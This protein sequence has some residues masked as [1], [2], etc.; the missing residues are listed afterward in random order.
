MIPHN[1]DTEA[2]LA[3][4][5]LVA[6]YTD[7]VNRGSADDAAQVWA[8]DGQLYFFGREIA[9][10]TLR[11]AYAQTFSAFEFLFQ[12]T[13]SGVVT[14]RG[15]TAKARWWISEINLPNGREGYKMFFGLYQDEVVRTDV[16]WRFR[17]RYLDE[18]RSIE[19]SASAVTGKTRPVPNFLALEF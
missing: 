4:R 18:I 16:G 3:I 15:D 7:A 8:P 5:Q 9:A 11:E 2:E 13:H 1:T 6:S 12:M 17:S 10:S 14:V 19:I